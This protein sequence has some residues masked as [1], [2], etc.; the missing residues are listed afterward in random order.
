MAFT[1]RHGG[2]SAAPF[3]SLNL[4]SAAGDAEGNV[5]RNLAL[6]AEAFG[7]GVGQIARMNQMHGADVAVVREVAPPGQRPR[8]D[9]MVTDLPGVALA[10]RVADCVPVLLADP[11]AGVAGCVHAGRAGL[12]EGV[13]QAAVDAMR[14]LGARQVTAWVGP[15][16]CGRCYE[17]PE[18][19]QQEVTAVVP[20]AKATT[21][22][23]TPALDLGAGVHAQLA[24]AGC[25]LVDAARCT[26]EAPDLFSYRRDGK[27]SGR[28]A[29]L[30][31]LLPEPV[32]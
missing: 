24:A 29:G 13:V 14:G 6:V 12:Y 27:Q 26:R 23:G 20:E 17:V 19:M 1:D 5:E 9:A 3:E 32:A 18:Q 10:V 7:V 21:S 16:V 28:L 25:E 31:R 15:H 22:W 2:V 4:G 8:V 11:T 30:V